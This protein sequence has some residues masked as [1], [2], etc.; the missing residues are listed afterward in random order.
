MCLWTQSVTGSGDPYAHR[1][2]PDGCIDLVLMNEEPP[3]VVGPYVEC[4]TAHLPPGAVIVGAR[5]HPG[6]AFSMLAHPAS[7]LL[8]QSVPVDAL[9]NKAASAPFAGLVAK[10]TGAGKLTALETGLMSRLSRAAPLDPVV[11]GVIEWLAGHPQGR[12]EQLSRWIGM[13]SR[14]LRRRFL[15]AVGYGPKMFQEVLRFQALLNLA[16]NAR[17]QLSLADLAADAGY[18]DQAHMSREVHRFSDI[19]ARDL[20]GSAECTLRLSGL[21][22]AQPSLQ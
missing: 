14:Q 17:E 11:T 20:L 12:V 18:A 3:V 15:A 7:A 22:K 8:N 13:S 1:V 6:R 9:W 19:Q 21:I 5:F 16:T 10:A 4:F 2:L